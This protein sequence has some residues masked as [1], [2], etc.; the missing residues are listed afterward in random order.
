MYVQYVTL[1]HHHHHVLYVQYGSK[2]CYPPRPLAVASSG[3]LVQLVAKFGARRGLSSS[4]LEWVGLKGAEGVATL[5]GCGR[6]LGIGMQNL[7]KVPGAI[8]R[9]AMLIFTFC[10]A[11]QLFGSH[12]NERHI[13]AE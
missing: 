1:I 11:S 2:K 8:A 3:C 6:G 7:N 13:N 12:K 4:P 9:L 10:F 5:R